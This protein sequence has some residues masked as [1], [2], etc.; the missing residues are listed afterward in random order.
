MAT[1]GD[2]WNFSL[3]MVVG[4]VLASGRRVIALVLVKQG[5]KVA[6]DDRSSSAAGES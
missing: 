3:A 2:E 1:V 6:N 4:L 5:T